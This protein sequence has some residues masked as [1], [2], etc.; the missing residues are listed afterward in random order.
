MREQALSV[1]RLS[2]NQIVTR[3]SEGEVNG[4]LVPIFNAGENWLAAEQHPQQAYLTV[5]APGKIKGPHLHLKRWGLFT[6]I[7]GNGRIVVR[8]EKGYEEFYSGEDHDYAT[9]Q[10]PAGVPAAIQNIGN[11]DAYFLNMP[12]PAWAVDD[13]DEHPVS[14]DD[15]DFSK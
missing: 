3:D 9:I 13:Q 14:F 4:F 1:R 7:K 2:H 6:C 11:T 15:Y 5:V 10:V 12:A 8:N